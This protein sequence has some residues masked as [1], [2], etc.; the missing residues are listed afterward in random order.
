MT[1]RI[2]PVLVALLFASGAQA[3][4][5]KCVADD[6][7]IAYSQVP[8]PSKESTKVHVP[9]KK[10]DDVVD[11]RWAS[12]FANDVVVRMRRGLASDAVFDSYGGLDSVSSGT[13]NIINYVF[14]FRGDEKVPAERISSL[15]ASMCKAGSLGDVRCEVLPY[16]QETSTNRCNPDADPEGGKCKSAACSPIVAAQAQRQQP[17]N[18]AELEQKNDRDTQARD[19]AAEAQC[20]KNYRDQI[21]AIDAQ[22]RQGY[23]SA[24][25]ERYRERLRTLTTRL[26][27]C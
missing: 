12:R 16:G 27:D 6:G 21:D 25:G 7:S 17:S 15:A 5:Y 4:I 18:S 8:C 19:D 22:M 1:Y 24:Q 3:E 26:R 20:K 14:R 2:A 13:V 23:D 10:I 11:C 9:V